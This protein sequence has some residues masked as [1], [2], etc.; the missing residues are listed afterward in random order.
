MHMLVAPLG[1][2]EEVSCCAALLDHLD[3]SAGHQARR[4]P[5]MKQRGRSAR[6]IRLSASVPFTAPVLVL[7][8]NAT[9]NLG[10]ACILKDQ[11]CVRQ[12]AASQSA[13][14]AL[15]L[16]RLYSIASIPISSNPAYTRAVKASPVS[17]ASPCL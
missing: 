10:K 3:R 6:L 1:G 13:L 17:G 8:T 4:P 14:H 16:G 15:D 11:Q 9:V 5:R 2:C 7:Q 12:L